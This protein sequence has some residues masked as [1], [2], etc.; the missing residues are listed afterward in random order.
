M[1]GAILAASKTIT[2][3]KSTFTSNTGGTLAGAV[4]AKAAA[5]NIVDNTFT[6]NIGN[7]AGAVQAIR[8]STSVVTVVNVT[9]NVFRANSASSTTGGAVLFEEVQATFA[10]NKFVCNKANTFGG[11]VY[12]TTKVSGPSTVFSNNVFMNNRAATR[13]GAITLSNHINGIDLRDN[14]FVKNQGGEGGGALDLA[15][16]TGA[17]NFAN[18]PNYFISNSAPS[19]TG[20]LAFCDYSASSKCACS[21]GERVYAADNRGSSLWTERPN[22]LNDFYFRCGSFYS[23][24]LPTTAG[25]SAD[26]TLSCPASNT[27]TNPLPTIFA[28]VSSLIMKPGGLSYSPCGQVGNECGSLHAAIVA[29]KSPSTVQISNGK[30]PAVY[31]T[32]TT[33]PQVLTLQGKNIKFTTVGGLAATFDGSATTLAAISTAANDANAALTFEG[34]ASAPITLSYPAGSIRLNYGTGTFSY[35]SCICTSSLLDH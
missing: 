4:Q 19:G 9:N 31:S 32:A 20:P 23:Q 15:L 1:T 30:L 24:Q 18:S 8:E 14:I 6:D 7:R 25:S 26:P 34:T 2:I 22:V 11:A 28:G 33:S 16:N 21:G 17:L 13:G 10:H 5:I 27:Y 12:L 3:E 35:V 29:S